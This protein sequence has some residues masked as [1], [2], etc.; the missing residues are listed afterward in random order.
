VRE[1]RAGLG[2]EDYQGDRKRNER[3][4]N[5]WRLGLQRVVHLGLCEGLNLEHRRGRLQWFGVPSTGKTGCVLCLMVSPYFE[6]VRPNWFYNC[7]IVNRQ[8]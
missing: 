8:L 6:S 7:S 3:I 2:L 5:G 4:C 1:L